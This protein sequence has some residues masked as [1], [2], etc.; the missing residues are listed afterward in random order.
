MYTDWEE[1]IKEKFDVISKNGS[2]FRD[3]KGHFGKIFKHSVTKRGV[4][5]QISKMKKLEYSVAHKYEVAVTETM[6]GTVW[7]TF[8]I[9]KRNTEIS[10]P[11]EPLYKDLLPVKSTK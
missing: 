6:S 7:E 9:Q 4:K 10:L 1:I 2:V 3:F 11:T 8:M 5:L